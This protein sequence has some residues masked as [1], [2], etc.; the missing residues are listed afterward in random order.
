M[1]KTT[2]YLDDEQ[3]LALRQLSEATGRPQAEL[4]REAVAEYTV[5]SSRPKPAG[6]GRFRSG[7]SDLGERAEELL[8]AAAE[9]REWD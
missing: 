1:L 7:R 4:I 8:N 9:K 3:V 5:R 2:V 6:A